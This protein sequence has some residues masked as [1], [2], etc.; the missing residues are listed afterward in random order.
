MEHQ[1]P[2]PHGPLAIDVLGTGKRI[3]LLAGGPGLSVN[4]MDTLASELEEKFMVILVHQR[5]TGKSANDAISPKSI[6]LS[7]FVEDIDRVREFLELDKFTLLGHSWGAMLAGYY[8]KEYHSYLEKLVLVGGGG[9][10]STVFTYLMD[11]ILQRLTGTEY[12]QASEIA[13]KL[14]ESQDPNDLIRF[15]K[16]VQPAYFFDK[17][18]ADTMSKFLD[19]TTFSVGAYGMMAED[20][21]TNGYSLKGALDEVK[22]P[23]LLLNGRQDLVGVHTA[24]EYLENFQNASLQVIERSG[25]YC[26]MDNAALFYETLNEFLQS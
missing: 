9:L 6:N 11:S 15:F 23:T 1:V 5:G 25:H 19:E 4:Y 17:K 12:A 2:T 16:L 10:D 21:M 20:L 18:N 26:W 13:A 7:A 8:A 24:A 14:P 22:T 3:M